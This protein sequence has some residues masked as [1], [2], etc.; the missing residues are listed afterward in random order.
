MNSRERIIAALNGSN[1]GRP[2]L[3]VMRQA[4]RYL[5]EYRKLKEK[6]GFL[7]MV[8]TPELACQVTLQPLKRFPLDAAILFCDI[9]V[10][11]EAMGQ[12]YK[13]REGG[14]ISMSHALESEKSIQA[15]DLSE[16][17]HKLSYV[18]EALKMLRNELDGQRALLGFAGSPWTLA[19]YMI[20]GES[21]DGFPRAVALAINNPSAFNQLME[22]LTLA[23]I[24]YLRMQARSGVDAVQIFDSW[25]SL[26]PSQ[27]AWDWSIKWISMIVENLKSEIPLILYAKSSSSRVD[28]LKKSNAHGLSLSHDLDLAMLRKRL[29][30]DYLLQGNLPPELLETS[31]EK[32][33]RETIAFLNKMNEDPAHI[34]NLGHGIR[35]QAK[36]ECMEALVEA[37]TE[38]K[39]I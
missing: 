16:I 2:P 24:D 18:K 4:G 26:C 7:E 20:Q 27:N 11:P 32:V 5:P 14:G 33:H 30:S 31:A 9:L 28:L 39:R 1:S 6:H 36:I 23:I 8:K 38:Y 21:K 29:P 10:I 13:F 25:Q 12:A 15:L 34:L 17:C 22:K 3:W 37:V 19:C 35:P